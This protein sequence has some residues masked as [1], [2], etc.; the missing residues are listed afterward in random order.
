MKK[1]F[2]FL[3]PLFLIMA[4]FAGCSSP[5]TQEAPVENK[6][7]EEVQKNEEKH[8]QESIEFTDD[9]GRVVQIPVKVE[10][11][12]PV[13]PPAEQMLLTFAPDKLVGTTRKLTDSQLEYIGRKYRKLP[14]FGSFYGAA[15]I[16]MEAVAAADPQLIIDIGERK[17]SIVDDMDSIQE[18]LEIPT[19]FIEATMETMPEAYTKLGEVLGEK[20][21]GK[22]LSD[23]CSRVY[24][25]VIET[26]KSIPEEELRTFVYSGGDAGLNV[27]SKK[28]FHAE[29]VDL[30]GK[31]IVELEQETSRGTGDPVSAEVML[32][33]DPD[34]IILQ[35]E[36]IYNR[37]KQD[38]VFSTMRAVKEGNVYECPADPYNWLGSPPSI[39]RYLGMQWLGKL[40]YPEKFDF[41]MKERTKEYYK[42]FYHYEMKDENYDKL[43]E[44]AMP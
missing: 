7:Q 3:L 41:D 18:Q 20:E 44:D 9:A 37:I 10:R 15:D 14:V 2:R 5:T 27:I 19:I 23:Y 36:S 11:I 1:R 8:S 29:V 33:W 43:T 17:E 42:L 30:M 4:L 28:S 31:N 6:N 22:E 13:G 25:E 16:N 34:F 40:F 38:Q 24:S 39:N 21:R 32:S 35:P 26:M 12:S